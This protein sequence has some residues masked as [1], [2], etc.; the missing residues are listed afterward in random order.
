MKRN[1]KKRRIPIAAMRADHFWK[2]VMFRFLL[3]WNLQQHPRRK[4]TS[5]QVIANILNLGHILSL[6]AANE[7]AQHSHTA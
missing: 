6:K 2:T 7:C 1:S 4:G 3:K 5:W